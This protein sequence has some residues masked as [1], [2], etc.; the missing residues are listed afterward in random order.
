ML[1]AV[2]CRDAEGSAPLRE[3]HLAAHLAHV[4][5][6]MSRYRVAGPL[7]S[8]AGETVGSLLIIE[9]A[10][11]EDARRFIES[12][13]YFAAGV[14]RDLGIERFLGVAGEWVGG[15]AWKR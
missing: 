4:E 7:K 1:F 9:A 8:A 6:N 10:D 13:P 5:G 15:A 14:W 3:Q 2:D 11:E 12:D